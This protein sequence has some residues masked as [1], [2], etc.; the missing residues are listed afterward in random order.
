MSWLTTPVRIIPALNT[1]LDA[2]LERVKY[3]NRPNLNWGDTYE[4]FQLPLNFQN[5]SNRLTNRI[6]ELIRPLYREHFPPAKFGKWSVTRPYANLSDTE[7]DD[8]IAV[9]LQKVG[10]DPNGYL[11][12][13]P[14][15]LGDG[16]FVR[17]CYHLLNNILLYRAPESFGQTVKT[18]WLPSDDDNDSTYDDDH[19]YPAGTYVGKL[20]NGGGYYRHFDRHFTVPD[21]AYPKLQG[22]WKAKCKDSYIYRYVFNRRN[23]ETLFTERVVVEGSWEIDFSGNKSA[24]IPWLPE[25]YKDI[26][27]YTNLCMEEYYYWVIVQQGDSISEIN[28]TAKNFTPPNYKYYDPPQ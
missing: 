6:R 8:A 19:G 23:S 10:I 20:Y 28:V 18:V 13:K 7:I 24:E 16:T 9:E 21:N 2:I 25:V 4:H 26:G 12:Q 3:T 15:L 27:Y 22:N 5:Q 11:W 1:I 14:H 17:A